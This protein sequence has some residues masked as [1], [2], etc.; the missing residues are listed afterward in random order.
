MFVCFSD[1]RARACLT[2]HAV[3]NHNIECCLAE[4]IEMKYKPGAD[5]Q[6]LATPILSLSHGIFTDR[7]IYSKFFFVKERQFLSS[8]AVTSISVL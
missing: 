1:L 2:E 8:D 4:G 6:E 5:E 7:S 3:E